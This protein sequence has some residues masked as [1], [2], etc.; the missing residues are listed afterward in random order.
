MPNVFK[1]NNAHYL[2]RNFSGSGGADA[3]DVTANSDNIAN[4]LLAI[5]ANT[6]NISTNTGNV[7]T[8]TT[9]I[10]TNATNISDNLAAININAANITTLQNTALQADADGW[11]PAANLPYGLSFPNLPITAK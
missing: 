9:N 1:I 6:G 11:L 8:N 4:N 3:G 7:S 2:V 10:S 5:N